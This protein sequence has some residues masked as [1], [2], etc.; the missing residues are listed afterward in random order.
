MEFFLKKLNYIL[1]ISFVSNIFLFIQITYYQ[2]QQIESLEKFK[3]LETLKDQLDQMVK[4]LN[5]IELK[6]NLVIEEPLIKTQI[7]SFEGWDIFFNNI[8]FLE[9]YSPVT[10]HGIFNIIISCCVLFSLGYSLYNVKYIASALITIPQYLHKAFF[11]LDYSGNLIRIYFETNEK[12][13]RVAIKF[14][15]SNYWVNITDFSHLN[16]SLFHLDNPALVLAL[17]DPIAREAIIAA[18]NLP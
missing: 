5:E 15:K 6:S 3:E 8:N 14:A 4:K 7:F 1:A 10:N 16:A 13:C 11:T 2:K 12:I 17:L 18:L 9:L